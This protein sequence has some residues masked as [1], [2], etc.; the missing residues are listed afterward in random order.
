MPL[1]IH[2]LHEGP[3]RGSLFH[4]NAERQHRQRTQRLEFQHLAHRVAVD[5]HTDALHPAA[6]A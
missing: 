4:A 3:H 6:G 5:S 2:G 1:A